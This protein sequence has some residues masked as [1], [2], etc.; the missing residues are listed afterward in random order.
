M[1]TTIHLGPFGAAGLA[2]CLL[3][4]A[5]FA[6][7]ADS[8]V[9]AEQKAAFFTQA[10]GLEK[11]LLVDLVT[12]EAD[13]RQKNLS[14]AEI[15]AAI[16]VALQN[17]ITKSGADPRAV[18]A[19][20]SAAQS[21]PS[22]TGYTSDAVSLSCDAANSKLLSKEAEAALAALQNIVVALIASD[23]APGALGSNGT[24]PLSAPPTSV[25]GGGSSDYRT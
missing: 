6:K 23:Q 22:G 5:G 14:S 11:N 17:T 19:A 21:C 24:S 9:T 12:A 8:P 18:L 10:S 13:A 7:T 25:G 20:L 15:V 4:P 2:M 1:K 3:A 16:Q